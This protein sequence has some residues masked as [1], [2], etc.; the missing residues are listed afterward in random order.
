M[1]NRTW[2]SVEL[3]TQSAE[4]FRKYLKANGF[5]YEPSACYNLIHFSVLCDEKET[6]ELESV[7]STL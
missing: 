7:L 6:E 4:T 2:K 1:N 5:K 3:D